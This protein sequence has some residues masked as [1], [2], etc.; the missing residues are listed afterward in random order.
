L[1]I[2]LAVWVAPSPSIVEAGAC[3]PRETESGRALVPGSGAWV[4]RPASLTGQLW[5]IVTDERT[6]L[7][8]VLG[9]DPLDFCVNED[10]NDIEFEPIHGMAAILPIDRLILNMEG[11]W[12]ASVWDIEECTC[13]WYTS[14]PSIATGTVRF[15]YVDTDWSGAAERSSW[16]YVATGTLTTETGDRRHLSV[17]V[18]CLWPDDRTRGQSDDSCSYHV[19]LH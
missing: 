19:R 13:P 9:F 4:I 14:V 17:G 6:G 1:L 5:W 3:L 2:V 18:R 12:V 11:D 8:A 16:G 10:W 7:T 15:H